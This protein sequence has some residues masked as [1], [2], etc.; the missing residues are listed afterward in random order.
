MYMDVSM[1]I[2]V[3][4]NVMTAFHLKLFSKIVMLV[5]MQVSVCVSTVLVGQ[6]VSQSDCILRLSS[7]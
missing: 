1:C 4:A 6:A 5:H 7:L 3:H 2:S